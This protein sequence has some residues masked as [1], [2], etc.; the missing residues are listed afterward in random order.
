[1]EGFFFDRV[2]SEGE[3][4]M[5]EK[6]PGKIIV[7][8]PARAKK[9]RRR[10]RTVADHEAFLSSFGSWSDMDTDALIKNIYESRNMPPR[11]RVDL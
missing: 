2:L 3:P 6:E 7:L 5:V 9:T 11:P 1:M 8:E 4:L 10:K